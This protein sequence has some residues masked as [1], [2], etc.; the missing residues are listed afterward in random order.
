MKRLLSI[1]VLVIALAFGGGTVTAEAQIIKLDEDTVILVSDLA[2]SDGMAFQDIVSDMEAAGEK[3]IQFLINT[4]GGH[5]DA[6][7]SIVATIQDMQ[8]RGVSFTT[9]N[10]GYAASAGAYIW[11]HGDVRQAVT[12]ARFMFH[13][14]VIMGYFGIVPFEELPPDWQMTVFEYN[15]KLRQLTLDCLRDTELVN[16]LM[17]G[18]YGAENWYVN[19]FMKNR[20]LLDKIL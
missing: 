1:A 14:T 13:S 6:M 12:D 19:A 11:I 8:S 20:G 18:G 10:I 15:Y 3:D 7:Y 17:G 5:A 4:D 16:E 9:V 2:K